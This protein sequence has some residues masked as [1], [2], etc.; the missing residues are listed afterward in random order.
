M[1]IL[2]STSLSIWDK[3]LFED[4]LGSPTWMG[5]VSLRSDETSCTL[6]DSREPSQS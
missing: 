1:Q 4:V 6:N 2:I 5:E 3:R